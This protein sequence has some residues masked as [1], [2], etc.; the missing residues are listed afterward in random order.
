MCRRSDFGVTAQMVTYGVEKCYGYS[1]G[2]ENFKKH[3]DRRNF[4]KAGRK[5]SAKPRN[6]PRLT[7]AFVS[8][9]SNINE[10]FLCGKPQGWSK[11][12]IVAP[13]HSAVTC[14]KCQRELN[15]LGLKG[16]VNSYVPL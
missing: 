8:H 11:T 5:T 7:S 13:A 1:H 4:E 12:H 6:A 3:K 2:D 16:H 10:Q 9:A 14:N 15:A